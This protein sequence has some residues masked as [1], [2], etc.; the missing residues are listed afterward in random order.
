MECTTEIKTYANIQNLIFYTD[1]DVHINI[2]FYN[3]SSNINS[4]VYNIQKALTVLKLCT[5]FRDI[6]RPLYISI[7]DPESFLHFQVL[8][9]TSDEQNSEMH[10]GIFDP[11]TTHPPVLLTKPTPMYSSNAKVI[12]I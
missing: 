5:E 7:A 12:D 9:D 4:D 6:T 8:N 1:E 3:K 2:R 11:R 10:I